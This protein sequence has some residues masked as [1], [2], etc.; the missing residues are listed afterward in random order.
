MPVSFNSGGQSIFYRRPRLTLFPVSALGR[1]LTGTAAGLATLRC[2]LAR[3]KRMGGCII[4]P[5]R[6]AMTGPSQQ[7]GQR[8]LVARL[9][10]WI[11]SRPRRVRS[12]Y[13]LRLI[14]SS[15]LLISPQ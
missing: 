2:D 12:S 11:R 10:G 9:R 3:S 14:S 6:P 4:G 8:G 13:W 1:L 5:G 7:S 15:S